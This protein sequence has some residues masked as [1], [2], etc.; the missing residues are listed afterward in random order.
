MCL[1]V[2][3]FGVHPRYPL[4]VAA[5]RDELHARAT[6]PLSR[7]TEPPGILAGRDLEAGGTWLGLGTRGRVGIVTNFRERPDPR[8]DAAALSASRAPSRGTLIPAFLGDERPPGE[9]L[10]RLE[11]EATRFAGFNLLLSGDSEL[12]YASNR[13]RPFARRLEPGLYG[14][15]NHLLDTPWPKLTRTRERLKAW[16]A[17]DSDLAP[18]APELPAV[19]EL[20]DILYD[21]E[22]APEVARVP[23]S[24]SGPGAALPAEWERAVSAP[25]VRHPLYGTRCSTVVLR[26]AAGRS[27]VAERCFAASGAL[28][29]ETRVLLEAAAPE[30]PLRSPGT[31]MGAP[32]SD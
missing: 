31:H 24:V 8:P 13:T 22:P 4:I 14:L 12:W 30:A 3:A 27:L 23:G 16:L 18:G 1:V 19:A 26:D 32:H 9:F 2:I 17:R 11:G 20:L 15:A 21:P 25:F 6:A 7:W 29:G 28:S 10:T 5:N